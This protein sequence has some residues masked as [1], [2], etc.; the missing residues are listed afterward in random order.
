MPRKFAALAILL[1]AC[2]TSKAINGPDGKPGWYTI[3]CSKSPSYCLEE[4][5]R[6]CPSGYDVAD[7]EGRQG[8]YVNN[9]GGGFQAYPTYDGSML[10]RCK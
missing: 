6:L 5:G 7:A 2:V 8:T 10:I 3:S 9:M 1:S 4:A